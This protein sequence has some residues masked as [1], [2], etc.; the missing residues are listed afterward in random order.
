MSEIG[1]LVEEIPRHVNECVALM[2]IHTYIHTHTHTG[3]YYTCMK[4]A[5]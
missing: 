2:Y 4:T 1:R 5:N 3:I